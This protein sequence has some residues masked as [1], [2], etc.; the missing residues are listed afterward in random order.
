M[1]GHAAAARAVLSTLTSKGSES[2]VSQA[3]AIG[4]NGI[5]VLSRRIVKEEGVDVTLGAFG[6]V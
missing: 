2:L 6:G 5:L 4:A 3:N 1:A